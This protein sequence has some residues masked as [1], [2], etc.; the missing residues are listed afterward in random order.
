MYRLAEVSVA[1]LEMAILIKLWILVS[2]AC[3]A[4]GW[5]L[6]ALHDSNIRLND[7]GFIGIDDM[8]FA[9]FLNPPLTTV[10]QPAEQ[11]ARLAVQQLLRR[12]AGTNESPV[13]VTLPGNMM[14]RAS[15]GCKPTA[16][17]RH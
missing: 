13:Q 6:S 7:I 15:C 8:E 11:F 10:A 2:T 14:L 17:K 3:V 5:I 16:P 4:S 12:T 1:Q 9:S